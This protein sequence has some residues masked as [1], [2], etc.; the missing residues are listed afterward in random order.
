M[1]CEKGS[2]KCAEVPRFINVRERLRALRLTVTGGVEAESSDIVRPVVRVKAGVPT[3]NREQR[4]VVELKRAAEL[5]LDSRVNVVVGPLK[6]AARRGRYGASD[7]AEAV[8][9]RKQLEERRQAFVRRGGAIVVTSARARDKYKPQS[10]C[11][12]EEPLGPLSG[13]LVPSRR[14]H[15]RCVGAVA[16]GDEDVTERRRVRY[17]SSADVAA[18]AGAAGAEHKSVKPA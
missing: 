9:G 2:Q 11:Y 5:V 7:D 10:A 4:Q 18:L 14:K 8:P 3:G 16:G 17:A 6:R 1:P 13:D 15:T 12:Y